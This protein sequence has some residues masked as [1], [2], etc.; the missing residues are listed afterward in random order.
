MKQI[1]SEIIVIG[2][3]LAGICAAIAA[4]REGK[5]VVLIQNRGVLGG[6][7]SSEI[8]VWVCGA[9]K[10]GVNRYARE[11]GIMGEL[12]LENQFRNP[13]G[14]VFQW[15]LLL[16]EKV[17]EEQNIQLYLNTEV[18]DV[19][20]E[21]HTITSVIARTQGAENTYQ[22]LGEYFIDCTGDG[23]VGEGAKAE[24][25]MGRESRE[26]YDESLA[27]EVA[28]DRMLGSTLLFYTKD[29]G[30]KTKFIAPSFAKKITDTTIIK[31]RTLNPTDNGCA[32]WW[33]EWGGELDTIHDN[34]KIRDELLSVVYGIWDHIKN[35]GEYEADTLDLEWIGTL[36][37]KRESRRFIGDYVLTQKDIEDQTFFEDRIAFG[38]WS[39]D[40]HPSTGMYTDAAGARH[41][42]ADGIYHLPYRMLYSK[43]IENLYFAGRNVSASHVAFGTI[44]V[45]ATCAI[46]GE[47]AGTA[48]AMASELH[49]SPRDIY[50]S[51]LNE[52]QQRML[53]NDASVIGLKNNDSKDLARTAQISA[54]SSLQTIDTEA[55][56][57]Q[58][59]PLTKSVGFQ[60]YLENHPKTVNLLLKAEA[61]T[62]LEVEFYTTGKKENYIPKKKVGTQTVQLSAKGRAW[63]PVVLPTLAE[64]ENLFVILKKNQHVVTHLSETVI[65][66]VLSFIEDPIQELRQ[67]ELHDYVRESPILYWTNQKI[68]RKNVVFNVPTTSYSK[69]QITNGYKRPFGSPNVWVSKL[70]S[71]KTEVLCFNWETPQTI[72]EV[73][74]TLNDD[75]NEDLVN[76][77]HHRT[78]FDIIPELIKDYEIWALVDGERVRL[79]KEEDNRS[80]Q[81]NHLF[82]KVKTK[83]LELHLHQTNGSNFKS[84]YE[85]RIYGGE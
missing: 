41:V 1:Q 28:D 17:K 56:Q 50:T 48:A 39:I 6:N 5:Q 83:Q 21:G 27:P 66:G 10:H 38:G 15:N 20:V 60:F 2:G 84:L 72:S 70:G 49:C 37:G 80:R 65:P 62:E 63:H 26:M 33:I 85:V 31:N 57:L 51:Y 46:L 34:E 7:S 30:E 77:H 71:K 69:E 14:N 55:E 78:A 18:I 36:P 79:A 24:F 16:L 45:M 23:I 11:T 40:L 59:F 9:T 13:Q 29:T 52:Y 44:R 68:N 3:G 32:Y 73:L 19:T 43:N 75:V 8:R 67:P 64:P 4:A 82:R 53:K 76:L 54:T 22:F 74:L 58:E 61:E 81:K 12:F 25:H 35:S 42:V 47:A